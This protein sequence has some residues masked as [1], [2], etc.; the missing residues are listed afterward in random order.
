MGP[1]CMS[2][3]AQPKVRVSNGPSCVSECASQ[4]QSEQVVRHVCQRMPSQ[5]PSEPVVCQSAPSQKSESV[6]CPASRVSECAK[7]NSPIKFMGFRKRAQ[8]RKHMQYHQHCNTLQRHG[9]APGEQTTGGTCLASCGL[10]RH[11]SHFPQFEQI[12]H[13]YCITQNHA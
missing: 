8:V 12:C 1:S 4:S 13:T 5:K 7:P 3:Y 6:K 9:L 10:L 11:R 2:E